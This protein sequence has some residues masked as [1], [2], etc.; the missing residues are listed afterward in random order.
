MNW[1]EIAFTAHETAKSKGW[2]QEPVRRGDELAMLMISEIAEAS[3]S[4]RRREPPLHYGVLEAAPDEN[5][6]Y[7]KQHDLRT[8]L[9]GDKS[10]LLNPFQA[11]ERT[12]PEGE[13][14]ELADCAIRILD[15][16]GY[17]KAD[18]NFICEMLGK[19]SVGSSWE[20]EF[21]KSPLLGQHLDICH[22]LSIFGVHARFDDEENSLDAQVALGSALVKIDRTFRFRL[23]Q[24]VREDAPE[25]LVSAWDLD[26]VIRLKMEYNKT[27]SYRHGGKAV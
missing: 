3:E 22:D 7:A 21:P 18:L 11:I 14:V 19:K 8:T 15:T 26:R 2:W 12:K 10:Y 4:V 20:S 17:L 13:A 24:A 5:S 25:W 6:A 23:D 9:V 27:R 1:N 16:A